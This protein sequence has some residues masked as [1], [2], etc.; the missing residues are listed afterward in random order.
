MKTLTL[1]L[2]LLLVVN[3]AQAQTRQGN[4]NATAIK[5]GGD[6]GG[7]NLL[8]KSLKGISEQKISEQIKLQEL[9]LPRFF[10]YL[11]AHYLYDMSYQDERGER[12]SA[13]EEYQINE[14]LTEQVFNGPKSVFK[15]LQ[16]LKFK[17][18]S[19]PCKDKYNKNVPASV[20]AMKGGEIC[21]STGMIK[22]A[23]DQG[24]VTR[25]TINLEI[26]LILAHEVIHKAGVESEKI[27]GAV[28]RGC[29]HVLQDSGILN[30]NYLDYVA[31]GNDLAGMAD[32]QHMNAVMTMQAIDGATE[33]LTRIL[34]SNGKVKDLEWVCDSLQWTADQITETVSKSFETRQSI[35]LGMLSKEARNLMLS[36]SG[37][38]SM[39]RTY[40]LSAQTLRRMGDR[41][42]SWLHWVNSI[43]KRSFKNLTDFDIANFPNFYSGDAQIRYIAYGDEVALLVQIEKAHAY[44]KK[45]REEVGYNVEFTYQDAV[46]RTQDRK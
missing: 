36:A 19:P 28:Q 23:V 31:A 15:I 30:G 9:S 7:G 12:V 18:Q 3:T 34:N 46:Y 37:L 24:L 43:D 21:I 4:N 14:A 27:V 44:M 5:G 32:I 6:A 42:E 40:C 39:S 35:L 25:Q 16:D 26:L 13:R 1:I 22:V 33:E 29:F 45:A 2:S 20:Y 17:Q 10:R 8:G 38:T 41:G 11:E